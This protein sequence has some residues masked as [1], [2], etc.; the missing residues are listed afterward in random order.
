MSNKQSQK[1]LSDS[2]SSNQSNSSDTESDYYSYSSIEENKDVTDNK[3]SSFTR[4]PNE[5]E[6]EHDQK[7]YEDMDDSVV[8]V[9]GDP[10]DPVEELKP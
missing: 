2:G 1:S 3:D 4:T 9:S 5:K 8:K 7:E 10:D 6:P